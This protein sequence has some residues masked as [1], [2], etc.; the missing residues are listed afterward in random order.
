L[1][2]LRNAAVA[3][4]ALATVLSWPVAAQNKPVLRGRVLAGG[5]P[6]AN[7]PVALHRVTNEGEGFTLDTT[8]TDL[9]GR[10]ELQIDTLG[11]PGVLFAA[12]RYQGELYIGQT[13]RSV[14]TSEYQLMVGPG[15]TPIDLDTPPPDDTAPPGPDNPRAGLAVIAVGVVLLSLVFGFALRHRIPPERRLLL[16]IAE[17]DNRNATTPVARYEEQRAELVR[18]L[19]ESA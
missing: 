16:E 17:L 14:P 19:R 6:V 2:V 1:S 8:T 4:F 9:A 7:Q 18:R 13:F 10:F 5:Q 15:A 11:L 3:L 12:A